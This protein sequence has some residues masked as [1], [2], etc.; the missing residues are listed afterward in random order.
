MKRIKRQL[1]K[2]DNP[3][4]R[5]PGSSKLIIYHICSYVT[6]HPLQIFLATGNSCEGGARLELLNVQPAGEEYVKLHDKGK[7]I[8]QLPE[9]ASFAVSQMFYDPLASNQ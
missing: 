1:S 5:P 7:W 3:H 9:E 2:L 4:H 8:Q 6:C